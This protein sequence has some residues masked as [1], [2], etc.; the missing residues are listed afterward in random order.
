MRTCRG[1]VEILDGGVERGELLH[2]LAAVAED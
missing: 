2:L 1:G